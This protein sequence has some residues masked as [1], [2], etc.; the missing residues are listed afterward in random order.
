MQ[1]EGL[2]QVSDQSAIESVCAEVIAEN[3]EQV[4]AYQGGKLGLIGWFVGQ[5]MRKTRG[6]AD[7][8]LVRATLEELL[9]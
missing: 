2:A 9:K 5:V 1:S 6:K 8:Q 7:P 4:A 3:P